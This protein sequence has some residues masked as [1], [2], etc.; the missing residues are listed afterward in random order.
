MIEE[1]LKQCTHVPAVERNQGLGPSWYR[2]PPEYVSQLI[3]VLTLFGAERVPDR[4][5]RE[6]GIRY[7]GNYILSEYLAPRAPPGD[8]GMYVH[9]HNVRQLIEESNHGK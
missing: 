7:K 9:K 8:S 4:T 5:D 3:S 6:L 1:I 2:V